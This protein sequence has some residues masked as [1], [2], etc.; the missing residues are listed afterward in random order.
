MIRWRK[1]AVCALGVSVWACVSAQELDG[2]GREALLR[3]LAI[4][5]GISIEK[6]ELAK[7]HLE[8]ELAMRSAL[9]KKAKEMGLVDQEPI[10]AS[11]ALA[12]QNALANAALLKIEESL[13]PSEEDLKMDYESFFPE[14]KMA[15][16]KF[17]IFTK[18]EKARDALNQ[19]KKGKASMSEVAS[20]ADD[21][22]IAEKRGD[23]GWV[24][25]EAMPEGVAKAIGIS[26]AQWPKDPI[27]TEFGHVI[28]QL[29]A[30]KSSRERSYEQAKPDLEK[31]RRQMMVRAELRKMSADAEK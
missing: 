1:W 24:P 15:Q 2:V 26:Q 31:A 10:K 16:I 21:Q 12:R 14:K 4:E 29:D 11:M 28:Y 6:F 18:V 30:V 7:P 17:A 27:K 8:R 3:Q 22:V 19:L 5:G 25:F 23:F 13:T 20:K 9:V